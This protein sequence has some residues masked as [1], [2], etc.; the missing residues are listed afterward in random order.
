MICL[1]IEKSL[2]TCANDE[3]REVESLSLDADVEGLPERE[4]EAKTSPGNEESR[5]SRRTMTVSSPFHLRLTIGSRQSV[6]KRGF[7]TSDSLISLFL[8]LIPSEFPLK[9]ENEKHGAINI[10]ENQ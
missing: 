10:K 8:P 3:K 6:Q 9:G 5:Y 1:V 4:G 7:K 2:L